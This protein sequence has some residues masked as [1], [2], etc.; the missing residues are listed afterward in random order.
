MF[1]PGFEN[2]LYAA[3]DTT[4]LSDATLPHLKF[5]HAVDCFPGNGGLY[6]GRAAANAVER[7]VVRT[8]IPGLLSTLVVALWSKNEYRAACRGYFLL[9][10][11]CI[12]GFLVPSTTGLCRYK[13]QWL[14]LLASA[15]KE[16]IDIS[17]MIPPVDIAFAWHVSR[18][19]VWSLEDPIDNDNYTLIAT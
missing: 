19:S 3:A 17:K 12:L 2:C 16:G 15:V 5:L 1:R 11:L 9:M 8:L 4:H 7:C 14:P 6:E 13:T 10:H 18:R